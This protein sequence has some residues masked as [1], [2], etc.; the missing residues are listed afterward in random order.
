MTLGDDLKGQ[1]VALTDDGS[2]GEQEDSPE[3]IAAPADKPL[4]DSAAPCFFIAAIL[5]T[6]FVVASITGGILMAAFSRP[7]TSPKNRTTSA[8]VEGA[9]RVLSERSTEYAWKVQTEANGAWRTFCFH[10]DGNRPVTWAEAVDALAS[11]RLGPALSAQ[12]RLSPHADTAYFFELPPLTQ[13]SAAAIPFELVTVA[14]PGLEAV[15]SDPRTFA[16]HLGGCAG[17]LEATAFANLNGDATL[18]SPCNAAPKVVEGAYATLAHFL[19]V[20]PAEQHEKLWTK[21]GAVLRTT[22]QER[23]DRPTWVSTEGSGVSWLHVRLDSAP[24]YY[25]FT[26]Y[27]QPPPH[28]GQNVGT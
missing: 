15:R 11:G 13:A 23:G 5:A 27:T 1:R 2:G 12:L 9:N 18:V 4:R 25:H 6:F 20:A 24:K 16:H 26:K 21:L 19:R 7:G 17:S 10:T 3:K 22:L 28:S 14:A 8:V